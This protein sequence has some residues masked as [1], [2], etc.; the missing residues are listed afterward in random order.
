[1]T[2]DNKVYPYDFDVANPFD[3]ATLKPETDV[4]IYLTE[5]DLPTMTD[6]SGGLLDADI[7]NWGDEIITEL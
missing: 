6:Q 3:F 4:P 7:S 5:I 1:M 2:T